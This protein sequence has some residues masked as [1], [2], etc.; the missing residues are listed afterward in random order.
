MLSR[1]AFV[2]GALLASSGRSD[3]V[4][5]TLER[6]WASVSSRGEPRSPEHALAREFL[7]TGDPAVAR[8][9]R[10]VVDRAV[11]EIY[12]AGATKAGNW[13][14]WEIGLPRRLLDAAILIGHRD[15]DLIAAV[16]HFV[17]PWRLQ[18]Y[19]GTSTGANR[20]D[21]CLVTLLNG[22]LSRDRR[23]IARAADALSPVFRYV[24]EG[25]GLYRDGSFIQHSTVPYQGTYGAS[26]LHGIGS[27]LR[28]LRGTPW[29]ITDPAL[30]NV[31]DSVEHSFLPFLHEGRM[32]DLVSGRAISRKA[33]GDE[34][35]GRALLDA[36]DLLGVPVRPQP[37]G[38]RLMRASARAVHRRPTWVAA[39]SMSSDR[40][41]HYEHGNGENLRGWHTGA[42][43]LYWWGEGHGSHYSGDFWHTVDPYRLP[44]TTVSTKRLPD[45]A[46]G[47][48][49]E[50]CPPAT[51]VGGASDGTY[52][53]V[54]QHLFGLESTLEARKSWVFLDDMVVCLGAGITCRDGV[55][56]ETIIDNRRT[57]AKLTVGDGW[58]HLEGHGGY[59]F[60]GS[61]RV[62]Q[63]DYTTL[64]LDHGTDPT[65]ASYSYL[66]LPN[67]DVATT[68]QARA[69]V[70]ANTP[71]H[72]AVTAGGLT[73]VNFWRPG[74]V[75]GIT[76]SEPAAVLYRPGQTL[77]AEPQK[78]S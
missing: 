22:I 13:W 75:A 21:L 15:D 52:A 26:M 3:D 29:E 35:R 17:R 68:K 65:D 34:R 12:H 39:L 42:G 57:R 23:R 66:L 6:N 5:A 48:W 76:V 7:R 50:S 70:V 56:V 10:E 49:G 72:Q 74:T 32:M 67:A 64:W 20:T 47:A 54:G 55:P 9:V 16:D 1:R 36:I 77:I 27:I 28:T 33:S 60:D 59:V 4:W 24:T 2:A 25:D 43:M 38:H 37:I 30:Q 11:R 45:G 62:R 78:S 46:G 19:S 44:G 71:D 31:F 8:E 69:T 40:I 63:D 41:A 61:L 14:N 58:A 51:W 18:F 53:T 73:A